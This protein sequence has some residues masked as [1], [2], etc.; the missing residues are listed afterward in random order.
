MRKTL[1]TYDYSH[2][3]AVIHPYLEQA[4]I[5]DSSSSDNAQTLFIQGK[6]QW[7]LKISAKGKLEREY[8]MT[9]F[10]HHH[11]MAPSVAAYISDETNDYL[12]TAA[13]QGEDGA[14]SQHMA[15]PE[16]LA[17]AFGQYLRMLHQLPLDGC[18]YPGR[19][20]EIRQEALDSGID[21][22]LLGEHGYTPV[23]NVI[24]HGDYCLPN[25]IMDHYE[26]RGF[27][28]NGYGGIGD[29]N[30]D[31]YWGLWTLNYNLDTEQYHDIFLDAYGRQDVDMEGVHYFSQLVDWTE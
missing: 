20:A 13:V 27:V 23:D 14:S 30:Y 19:S 18:P 7:F 17:A 4:H 3:P 16:Q 21:P 28:D 5:Y 6:E 26:F 31:I 15:N 9:E 1:I 11:H 2:I 24:I 10:L 29:R 22:A 25:L 8:R 12:L